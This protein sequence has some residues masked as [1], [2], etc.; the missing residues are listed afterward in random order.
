MFNA[1]A[2][3]IKELIERQKQLALSDEA[4]ASQELKIPRTTWIQHKN[5]IRPVGKALLR[6]IARAYPDMDSSVIAALRNGHE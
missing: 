5:M 2:V 3:L 6:A 4:F 1:E